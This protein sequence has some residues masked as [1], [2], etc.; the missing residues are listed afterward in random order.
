M[1]FAGS[2]YEIYSGERPH[3][4]PSPILS[5]TTRHA[6]YR[7][8]RPP[9]VP[10]RKDMAELAYGFLF[11]LLPHRTCIYDYYIGDGVVGYDIVPALR[12]FRSYVFGIAL[13]HLAAVC[14]QIYFHL[15]N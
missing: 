8:T 15:K 9:R 10:A 1:G 13:V 11:S 2:Q 4:L 5:H 3:E 7:Q 6:D 14:A 12:K